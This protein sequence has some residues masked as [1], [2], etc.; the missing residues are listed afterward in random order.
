MMKRWLYIAGALLVLVAIGVYFLISSIDSIVKNAVEKIGSE[1]TG[2]Q[3]RLK[4]VKIELTAG[5]GALRGLTVG[6]PPGFKT[7]KALSLGEVSLKLDVGSIAKQT[8]LIKEIAITAPEITYEIGPQGSNIDALRRNIEAYT[9]KGNKAGSRNGGGEGKKLV[10]EHLYIRN[11]KVN[12]S[13]MALKEQILSATLAD[14]HLTN[15]GKKEGGATG[16]ELARQVLAA[17]GRGTAKVTASP[18]IAKLL[19]RSGVPDLSRALGGSKEA[20]E[21]FKGLFGK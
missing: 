7:E 17:I 20:K 6:N 11:G 10:V 16:A 14:I 21:A 3:V 18:D 5:R 13:A 15:I 12:V 4:E 8:V 2:A 9:G 19:G 1:A